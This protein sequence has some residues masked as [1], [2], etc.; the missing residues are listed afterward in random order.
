[1]HGD[2]RPSWRLAADI[3][4][5]EAGERAVQ[6]S[7]RRTFRRNNIDIGSQTGTSCISTYNQ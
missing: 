2:G 6:F 4:R 7:D 3:R 1:M 5:S